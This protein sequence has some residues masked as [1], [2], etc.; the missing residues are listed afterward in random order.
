MLERIIP[1]ILQP[2]AAPRP[3]AEHTTRLPR[4]LDRPAGHR[5]SGA[6]RARRDHPAV[7]L[8]P[9]CGGR[10]RQAVWVGSQAQLAAAADGEPGTRG[11]QQARGSSEGLLGMGGAESWGGRGWVAAD[12]YYRVI[13]VESREL[14]QVATAEES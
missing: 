9:R 11:I 8:E 4:L 14:D 10:N 7:R 12:W 13:L 6:A 2:L 5:I 1:R 3:V